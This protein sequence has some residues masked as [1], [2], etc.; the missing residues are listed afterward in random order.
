[1]FIVACVS[2]HVDRFP[3]VLLLLRSHQAR[4]A[5]KYGPARTVIQFVFLYPTA[6]VLFYFFSVQFDWVFDCLMCLYNS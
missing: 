5:R 4:P 2:V 6:R 3:D 1:M